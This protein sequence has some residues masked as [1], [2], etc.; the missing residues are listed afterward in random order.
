MKM[1]ATGAALA[2]LVAAC[3][4]GT[5]HETAASEAASRVSTAPV[6]VYSTLAEQA[7]KPVFDA[8]TAETGVPVQYV[9]DS[10]QSLLENL[11]SDGQNSS[12]DLL[13]TS[14][15]ATLMHAAEQ[16]VLRPTYSELLEANIPDA[17]HDPEKTWFALS[18]VVPAIV[19]DTRKVNPADLGGYGGLADEEWQGKLCLATSVEAANQ[20]LVAMMIAQ[21]G[22]RPTELMVRGWVRNLATSVLPDYSELLRAIEAGQCQLGIVTSPY[23]ARLQREN[24]DTPVALFWPPAEE[25]G[26]HIN[27]SGAAVTRHAHNPQGATALLEW[28]SGA[29]G[30]RRLSSASFGYPVN[31]SVAPH[32]FSKAW[33]RYDA[34]PINMT[35]AGMHLVD[36]VKLMERARYR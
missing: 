29:A 3:G 1:F 5:D 14:D 27:M 4:G 13:L 35:Q 7:V 12:A 30:Q 17:L 9:I 36:A 15:A 11:K 24:A 10:D 16:D 31:A 6:L 22:E 26:V 32:E 20:T 28:M 34:S 2:L 8:Y 18:V 33:G 23:F 25:G 21:N 19:Y